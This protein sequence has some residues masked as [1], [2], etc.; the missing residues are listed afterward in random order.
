MDSLINAFGFNIK[1]LIAELINFALLVFLLYKL[2]FRPLMKFMDE[3]AATIEKGLED[4]RTAAHSLEHAGEQASAILLDA[5][6]QAD[7]II[8]Q[9]KAHAISLADSMK[10]DARAQIESLIA[11]TKK[12]IRQERER[13]VREATEEIAG[14]VISLTEK[15]LAQKLDTKKDAEFVRRSIPQA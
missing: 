15:L 2:G 11:K 13:M 4:A 8:A 3:R 6:R 7:E 10:A 5:R 12:D 1:T 14:L 9:S